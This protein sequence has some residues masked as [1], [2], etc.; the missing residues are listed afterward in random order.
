ME[1]NMVIIYLA[2][3]IVL[4][5]VGKIFYIPLKHIFKLFVNTILGGVLIYMVNFIGGSYGFHLGLNWGTAIFA[6]LLG[7]PRSYIFNNNKINN[8]K[9][10]ILVE[11]FNLAAIFFSSFFSTANNVNNTNY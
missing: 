9:P 5:I 3:L 11:G 6:G 1:G 10:S 8:L 4:F 2:C 7:I